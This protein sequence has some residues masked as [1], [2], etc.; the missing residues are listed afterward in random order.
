MEHSLTDIFN[1]YLGLKIFTINQTT[2]TVGSLL[3]FII[4]LTFVI[5]LANVTAYVLRKKLL[6]KLKFDVGTVYNLERLS[7]YFIILVGSLICFQFVGID[8]SGLA[9][10]FGLFSVG[11]GFGLQNITSNFVAGLIL[12]FERP[13][14]VGDR[15]TIGD[16]LGNVVH[17]NMRATT[18]NSVDNVSIIV[19]NSDFISGQVIN[20]SYGDKKIRLN[21]DVGTSYGSDLD[22]VLRCLKEVADENPEVMKKPAPEAHFIAFGDSS[23][24]F[25]LRCWIADPNKYWHVTSSLNCDIA[26]KF[27]KHNVEIPFP[28]RDLHIRSSVPIENTHSHGDKSE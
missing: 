28:Q 24:N 9:V 17:I 20:W 19:P 13:I 5:V 6:P 1:Q 4:L 11:I 26:R 27:K 15:V 2:V 16:T 12:L 7:K 8:L 25:K 21:I 3:T 18:I 23:W 22:L 10:I 14:K